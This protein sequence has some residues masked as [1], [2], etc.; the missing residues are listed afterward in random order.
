MEHHIKRLAEVRREFVRDGA[1]DFCLMPQDSPSV[2]AL[3]AR[4]A[5]PYLIKH[6][7]DTSLTKVT[8]EEEGRRT[9][10]P[11]GDVCLNMRLVMS[12][13]DSPATVAS[14]WGDPGWD[15]Y[16]KEAYYFPPNV[17]TQPG[18]RERMKRTQECWQQSLDAGTLKWT[19]V[20]RCFP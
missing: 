11:L 13:R 8:Y 9:L 1:S 7:S 19:D 5:F 12:G 16:A 20:A 14:E 15:S 10:V 18:G 3:Y 17:L 4:G 2:A 6:L